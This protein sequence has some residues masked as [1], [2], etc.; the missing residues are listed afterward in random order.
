MA[1]IVFDLDGTLIDSAPDIQGV[2]N[3]IL[4]DLGATPLDLNETHAFIGNGAAV[5]VD[6]M[7]RARGV[8][9]N[10]HADI[11]TQFLTAYDTAVTLTH[12]YPHVVK[13]LVSLVASG[14]RLGLCTN[15]PLRPA[16]AVLAHL[17]LDPFF[18]AVIGGDSLDT[19]KP[20]PVPLLACF[21]TLV[22][23]GSGADTSML[24]VGDSEVDAETADR[25]SIP[26]LLFTGGYHK[27]PLDEVLQTARFDSFDTLPGLITRCLG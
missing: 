9:M 23:S 16:R 3:R 21:E 26:F 6:R 15:K 5:F 13:A 19:K 20:D 8:P 10:Q 22:S 4:N 27:G 14:H 12:P 24:Y 11:L 1:R 18:D 7:C 2:A 25:A 17:S